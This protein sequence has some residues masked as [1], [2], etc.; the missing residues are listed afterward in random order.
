M[1][2]HHSAQ[3]IAFPRQ[4]CARGVQGG[5]ARGDEAGE[6]LRRALRALEE[7]VAKQRTAVA[8]WRG[9]LSELGGSV[10]TLHATMQ[11][12]DATL[13]ELRGRVDAVTADARMLEAWADA[14]AA[15][16]GTM[17]QEK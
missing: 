7:A 15:V 17:S 8:Q 16:A 6:R 12:Y 14:A 3:V 10:G 13:G 5:V 11:G 9:A 2:E 4:P 1:D